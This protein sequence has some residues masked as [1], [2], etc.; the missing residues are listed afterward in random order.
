DPATVAA[1]VEEFAAG[2]LATT[3][4]W[5]QHLGVVTRLA[6]AGAPALRD[7]F[8]PALCAGRRRAGIALQAALRPGPPAMRVR[9]DGEALVLDGAVPWVTGWGL[10]DLVLVAARNGDDVAFVLADARTGPALAVLP[11]SMVAVRA[12][13]TV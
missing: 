13:A 9:R 2:D 11:Q 10:V 5:L 8:L 3:F 6:A 4:V 1:V 7:T 12:S